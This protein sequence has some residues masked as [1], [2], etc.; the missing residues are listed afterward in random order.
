MDDDVHPCPTDDVWIAELGLKKGDKD[1]LRQKKM[2]NNRIINT[3]QKL[4]K[5]KFCTVGGL[6][7]PVLSETSFH[8]VKAKL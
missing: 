6:Q 5:R 7:D 3:A 4:I 2:L 1:I 8:C